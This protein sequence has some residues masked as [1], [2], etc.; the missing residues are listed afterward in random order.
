MFVSE[1][2]DWLW[3]TTQHENEEV[4]MASFEAL[5]KF[6]SSRFSLHHFPAAVVD[7]TVKNSDADGDSDA[8]IPA[9]FYTRM[10][11]NIPVRA[12]PGWI[13]TFSFLK[14][15]MSLPL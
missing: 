2:V 8:E 12:L 13:L 1:V 11:S 5:S 10:L 15:V 14:Q 6:P 4:I 9:V 3:R 7:E